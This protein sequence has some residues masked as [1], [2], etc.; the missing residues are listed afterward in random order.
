MDGDLSAKGLSGGGYDYSYKGVRSLWR[1]PKEKMKVL[2]ADN[3]LYFTSRG[4][5]RIKR[6]LDELK[7]VLM[8]DVWLDIDPINSRA[9][10]RQGYPTQK[11]LAL[12][13]RIIAASCPEFG[14]VFDPFCG[15]ATTCVAAERQQRMWIGCDISP[16]AYELVQKRMKEE[17]PDDLL[18]PL[19]KLHFKMQ[20]PQRTDPGYYLVP[21]LNP[22]H[23]LYGMQEGRCAGCDYLFE[24]RHFELDHIIPKA[25]GGGDHEDNLQLLCSSCNRIKGDRDMAYLKLRLKE[26][27]PAGIIREA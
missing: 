14:V 11:P 3:R 12:L 10:E 20:V 4:G 22:R 5:I 1:V 21:E 18:T 9:K 24:F 23:R 27:M 16:K 15:C 7:G 8:G 19:F 26:L 25:K 2:D 13:E 6:Y 17:V